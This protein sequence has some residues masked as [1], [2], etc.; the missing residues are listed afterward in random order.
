MALTGSSHSQLRD[1]T[2]KG[3]FSNVGVVNGAPQEPGADERYPHFAMNGNL[4]Y[5]VT[6]V[7]EELVEQLVVPKPYRR[8]VMDLAHSHVLGGHLGADKTL[9]RVLQRFYWPG[10]YREIKDYCQSCPMCQ[11]TSPVANF[12]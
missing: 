12:L 9:E 6:K 1:E 2:L 7:R 11:V 8:M 10:C 4:L 5:R 3:A